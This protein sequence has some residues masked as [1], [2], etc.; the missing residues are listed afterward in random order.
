MWCEVLL[1]DTALAARLATQLG[2][3]EAAIAGGIAR[4]RQAARH[5]KTGATFDTAA[6]RHELLGF[7]SSLSPEIEAARLFCR[8]RV[9]GVVLG[10]TSVASMSRRDVAAPA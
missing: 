4:E 3:P 6:R 7:A 8:P 9:E 5:A 10:G 2:L 1:D